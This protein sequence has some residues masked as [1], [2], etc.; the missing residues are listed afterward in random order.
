MR[1]D[2][3]DVGGI[4]ERRRVDRMNRMDRIQRR[5][6]RGGENKG[7]RQISNDGRVQ[8]DGNGDSLGSR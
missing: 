8:R 6:F 5:R 2:G 3:W 1:R 7:D 4:E